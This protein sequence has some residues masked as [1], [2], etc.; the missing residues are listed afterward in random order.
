MLMVTNVSV[1]RFYDVCRWAYP[2]VETMFRHRR[3]ALIHLVNDR[4]PR[5]LLEVGVGPGKHL[6]DYRAGHITVVD[7]SAGMIASCQRH[8]PS[9]TAR[10]MDGE[11]LDFAPE[12]FDC[13][14]LSHVLTVTTHPEN[15]LREALRVLEPGGC[16]AVLTYDAQ[17]R[18]LRRWA[19]L[20][21]WFAR[22][23]RCRA[24]F[25]LNDLKGL[26]D[27]P[28]LH[29]SRHGHWGQFSLTLWQK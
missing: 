18:G 14:V 11:A 3:L 7:V 1:G 27:L 20:W 23:L 2:L 17:S 29:Q 4:A 9:A 25:R 6:A 8:F 15:L 22:L 26:N 10:V 13:V 5:R 19:F 21:A 12:A 24:L 16:L 28:M